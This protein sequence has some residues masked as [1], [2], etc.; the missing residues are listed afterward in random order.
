MSCPFLLAAQVRSCSAAPMRKLITH[1]GAARDEK[2]SS[3]GFASC[4]VYSDNAMVRVDA[5]QCPYLTESMVQYCGAA[6]TAKFVPYHEG[7]MSRCADEGY[8]FCDVYLSLQHP[9]G[10]KAPNGLYYAPNHMWLDL[11][12]SGMCHIGIDAF[13]AR[14]LGAVDH[15]D[16]LMQKGCSRP[17]AT[18]TR[19]GVTWVMPFPNA[20][21]IERT[22]LYLRSNPLPLTSDCYGT[23]WLFAGH[24]TEEITRGLIRGDEAGAWLEREAQRMTERVHVL[25]GSEGATMN[26]GGTFAPGFLTHLAPQEALSIV[27]EF[28]GS[29]REWK[30]RL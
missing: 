1:V 20:M 12:E 5:A 26:D 2:C 3:A 22:N 6:A 30:G 24:A 28:F 9:G 23:G 29:H 21:V 19:N 14:V 15:I 18:L 4:R 17:A 16:F 27:H 25:S 10:R 11:T 13:L 7:M 8:R